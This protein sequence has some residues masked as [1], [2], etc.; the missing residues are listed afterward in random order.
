MSHSVYRPL[1]LGEGSVIA[2]RYT[3]AKIVGGDNLSV[4]LEAYSSERGKSV[5]LRLFSVEA[6]RPTDKM[7]PLLQDL[8]LA[9]EISHPSLLQ[10]LDVSKTKSDELYLVYANFR[11]VTL[12]SEI[13]TL[14]GQ[15]YSV[16]ETAH[17]IHEI[18]KALSAA[19]E[20]NLAHYFL[21]PEEILLNE[22]GE[23]RLAGLGLGRIYRGEFGKRNT[24]FTDSYR[25]PEQ[26]GE[27]LGDTKSDLYSLGIIAY[28]MLLGFDPLSANAIPPKISSDSLEGL[29]ATLAELI[30]TLT[31]QSPAARNIGVAEVVETLAPFLPADTEAAQ[32]AFRQARA[33]RRTLL[34]TALNKR[35][36]PAIPRLWLVGGVACLALIGLLSSLLFLSE[37]D[38]A[39]K[40][41]SASS[42]DATP[43]LSDILKV[44][45][46]AKKNFAAVEQAISG[47]YVSSVPGVPSQQ[48]FID[49]GRKISIAAP[50]GWRINLKPQ[51]PGIAVSFSS[52]E[53]KEPSRRPDFALG[54]DPN[55]NDISLEEHANRNN[56]AIF[57]QL[58]EASPQVLVSPTRVRLENFEALT[59]KI[60]VE[61]E[62]GVRYFHTYFVQLGKEFMTLNFSYSGEEE[63]V[64]EEY[65]QQ[66]V[67]SLQRV[68]Q[69]TIEK[70]ISN[71]A[72]RVT[73]TQEDINAVFGAKE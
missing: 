3:V 53:N 73:Q 24:A 7:R 9:K 6:T 71:N 22:N 18:A 70:L 33:E 25:A 48:R 72:R 12:A 52:P 47:K 28:Q 49:A 26:H 60:R 62:H 42:R 1:G 51:L 2:E 31:E 66:I 40:S 32:E 56:E 21:S 17:V 16:E 5:V 39:P 68:E 50:L 13:R 10:L 57:S 11:F 46:L 55:P 14:D 15:P 67:H 44:P 8:S 69:S 23:V 37:K 20:K 38:S 63:E 65:S 36:A 61:T 19:N 30:D 54:F 29:A 35:T 43:S 59:S 45:S 41:T 64:F 27:A 34:S 58:K 4:V